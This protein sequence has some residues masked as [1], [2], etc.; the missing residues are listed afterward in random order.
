MNI[1]I[2]TIKQTQLVS[3]LFINS[4]IK[5]LKQSC[6]YYIIINI[7]F[8]NTIAKSLYPVISTNNIAFL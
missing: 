7:L 3:N 5:V 6:L 8:V 2:I 1:I 4:F